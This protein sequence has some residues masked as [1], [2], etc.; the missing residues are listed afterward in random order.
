MTPAFHK[1]FGPPALHEAGSNGESSFRKGVDL[2]KWDVCRGGARSHVTKQRPQRQEA[3][4]G[5]SCSSSDSGNKGGGIRCRR[6]YEGAVIS[7]GGE[8]GA[9][10][11]R[12]SQT[13]KAPCNHAREHGLQLW[14]LCR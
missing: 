12:R 10:V 11:A 7:S 2:W 1:D 9:M 4:Q 13:K 14:P 6:A 8:R 5:E 3:E